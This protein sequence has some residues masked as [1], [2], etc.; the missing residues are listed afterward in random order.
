MKNRK[1]TCIALALLTGS[2]SQFAFGAKDE[3]KNSSDRDAMDRSSMSAT[4]DVIRVSEDRVD[5]LTTATDLIGASVYDRDGEKVGTIKD[6]S[7][8]RNVLSGLSMKN[9]SWKS[10]KDSKQSQSMS[11]TKKDRDEDSYASKDSM[12][13]SKKDWNASDDRSKM[14]MND[15]AMSGRPESVVFI[16][17]GGILGIG[18]DLVQ[19]PASQ[20]GYDS[21]KKR[22]VLEGHSVSEVTNIA[23]ADSS[24]EFDD[25]NYY[26]DTW[27]GANA[28]GTYPNTSG[29]MTARAKRDFGN[30]E[31]MIREAFK[32]DSKFSSLSNSIMIN[33]KDD[34]VVL[35]GTV[36]TREEKKRA[37]ELA[38]QETSL[39]VVNKIKVSN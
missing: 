20:I 8:G 28:Y 9:D 39:N 7:F 36:K 5:S 24:R 23:E 3:M 15:H 12:K 25:S 2:V 4:Q 1:I 31:S 37:E 6:V 17:V 35:T 29:S 33:Q 18:D 19:V 38:K 13:D 27:S 11:S 34:E 26:T 32:K 16:S 14:S 21:S 30:D 22:F 10:D